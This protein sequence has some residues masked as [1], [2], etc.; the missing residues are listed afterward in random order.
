[1]GKEKC[2]CFTGHRKIGGDFFVDTLARGILYLI[3]K[4]VDTFIVGGALGFDTICA[5]E[6][7]K[8]KKIH[9]DIK[10]HVYAPCNN[11]SAN[12]GLRDRMTYNKILK[13]ADYVDMP[14]VPYYDGCMKDRNYKMVDNAAY[15]I[16]YFNTNTRSGTAQTYRYAQSKG[17]TI[18]NIAGKK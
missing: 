11:Q 15:C 17:L 4:G 12:W 9:P 7:L 8:A 2:C 10:L 18:F 14:D 16:C 6:V 1:M 13:K 5:Q 3:D